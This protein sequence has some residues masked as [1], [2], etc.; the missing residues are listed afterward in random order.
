MYS[1][2]V[3]T[4]QK[5]N[6]IE[7]TNKFII[8]RESVMSYCEKCTRH[9]N[10]QLGKLKLL[11][12]LLHDDSSIGIATGYGMDGPE[13][14]SKWRRDFPYLSRPTLADNQPPVQWVKCFSRGK[15]WPGRDAD[16]S[17][18]SSAVVKKE[19]T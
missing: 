15:E 5:S 7:K 10:T 6:C 9:V 13:I 2:L 18:T 1:V 19:Y 3:C 8:I 14:E 4:A 11:L 17:P 16:P 12:H